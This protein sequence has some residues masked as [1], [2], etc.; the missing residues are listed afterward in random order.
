MPF[1]ALE[2]IIVL[3]LSDR[4]AASFCAKTLGLYGCE[5]ITVASLEGAPLRQWTIPTQNGQVDDSPIFLQIN[6]GNKTISM[7]L[8]SKKGQSL[9][10]DLM[11]VSDVVIESQKPGH[12][13]EKGFA[14]NQIKNIN[15]SDILN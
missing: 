15:P 9:L 2:E 3:D 4:L 1:G 8:H 6:A 11:K 12:W 10:A 14:Y 13:E 7:D 5:V